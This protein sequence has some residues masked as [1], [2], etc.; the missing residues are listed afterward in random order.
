M[1]RRAAEYGIATGPVAVDMPAV[2]ARVDRIVLDGRKGVAGL[3]DATPGLVVLEGH[4]R[5]TGPRTV[6]VGPRTLEA[7][8]IF[9]NVGAGRRPTLPGSGTSRP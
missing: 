2:R 8:R 1:A 9:L 6:A 7:E 3:A 4:A 5:L